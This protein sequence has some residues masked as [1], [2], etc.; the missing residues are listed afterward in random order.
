MY[1]LATFSLT[2]KG[3]VDKGSSLSMHPSEGAPDEA[4]LL[5]AQF[6][7]IKRTPDDLKRLL[8]GRADPNIM[9]PTETYGSL[10]PLEKILMARDAHVP[11]FS[12]AGASS[13]VPFT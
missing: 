10:C 5:L 6:R 12:Y 3:C 9:I 8:E 1:P 7:P 4:S 11:M 13:S 2:G